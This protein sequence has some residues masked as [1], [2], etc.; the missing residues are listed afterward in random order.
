MNIFPPSLALPAV[1]PAVSL[2]LRASIALMLAAAAY[3]KA[4]DLTR[5]RSSL[6]AYRLL[7][8][9]ALATIAPFVVV[10]ETALAIGLLTPGMQPLA[11][12]TAAGLLTVYTA[13]IAIN[14]A[15]GR[16]NLDCGCGAPN[17]RQ[18]ISPGLIARNA[19][20]IAAAVAAGAPSAARG[21]LWLD[22]VALTGT[23][24]CGS[25]LWTAAHGLMAVSGRHRLL[26]T[27]EAES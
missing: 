20:L 21:L 5:F 7:P 24:A 14:L 15:R 26:H 23:L 8:D 6:A 25:L 19:I 1:D 22:A 17:T 13:A 4:T 27:L 11:A 3:H 12:A 18:P 9:R 2:A 10:L 16:R